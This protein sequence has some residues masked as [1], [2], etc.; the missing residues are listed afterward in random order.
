MVTF[1]RELTLRSD[2]GVEGKMSRPQNL[3]IFQASAHSGTGH[4]AEAKHATIGRRSWTPPSDKI[5]HPMIKYLNPTN[6][7]SRPARSS[8]CRQL[9]DAQSFTHGLRSLVIH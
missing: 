2:F 6:L 4:W 3:F 7:H 8:S 5:K 1:I 9:Q